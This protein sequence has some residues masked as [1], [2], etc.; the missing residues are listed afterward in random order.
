MGMAQEAAT[1]QEE[2]VTAMG[3]EESAALTP[4]AGSGRAAQRPEAW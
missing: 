1:A 4:R 2:T 3:C